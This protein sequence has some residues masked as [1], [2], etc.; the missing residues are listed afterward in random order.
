MK[1]TLAL[2]PLVMLILS[3]VSATN[4]YI[5]ASGNDANSG[6]STSTPWKTLN[7][8]NSFFS[9][10]KP[11]DNVYLNRGD[12]FYGSITINKSGASGSPITISAYGSGADPVI[13]GFTSVGSWTSVGTN[14]WE[15][16][17]AISSLSGC[18]MVLVNGVNVAMGR[19]PNSGY[20]TYQSFSGL[21]SLTSSSLGST[22]W[23]GAEVVIRKNDWTID[24][25]PIAA[26]AGTTITYINQY[27]SDALTAN[28]GFF[29][30]NDPR[31]LDAQNEWYYNPST[32]KIRVYS[33]GT[34][35]NVQVSTVSSLVINNGFDYINIDNIT[36]TGPSENAIYFSGG[37]SD[38]CNVQ[39]CTISYCGQNGILFTN[40]SNTNITNNVINVCNRAGV[41]SDAGSN[42]T[43]SGNTIT[44]IGLVVGQAYDAVK[45]DGIYAAST[46]VTIK[47]NVVK[48]VSYNGII[49][50]YATGNAMVQYNYVDGSN[51]VLDD[52]G[53]IYT[54]SKA[55]GTRT[56]DH[57]ISLNAIGNRDGTNNTTRSTCAGIYLDDNSNNVVVT[58]NTAANCSTDGF[59]LHKITGCTI[60]NN[61]SYNNGNRQVYFQNETTTASIYNNKMNNNIF[62][63]RSYNSSNKHQW[64]LGFTSVTNDIANFGTADYNYYARPISEGNTFDTY[65]SNTG[66]VNR[67]LAS[68]QSFTGQDAHSKTSPVAITD[69]NNL[70]FE[71]NASSSSKTINLG[72]TYIDMM[73]NSYNGSITLAPYSSAVLIKTGA[74]TN[75]P[76][77]A[78]AGSDQT[79]TLPASSVTL[80]GTGTDPDGSIASYK[81]SQVSG[82]STSVIVSPTA[83]S[84]VVNNLVQGVYKFQL[85][86][87]DNMGATG[88]DTVQVTVNASGSSLLLPALNVTN[89]NSGLQYNYYQ[90][91]YSTVP[92]FSTLTPTSSG[93]VS[94][95]T[96]SVAGRSTSFALQFNGYIKVPADGNYT[97]YTTSDDGSMLYIDDSLVVNNDGLHS[98]LEKSGSIGLKAGFHAITVGYTQGGGDST[99][100]VS[101]SSSSIS[102]Q[103]IPS[104]ILF[105]SSSLAPLSVNYVSGLDYYYYQAGFTTVP[106]FS[107]LTPTSSGTVNSFSLSVAKRNYGFALQFTGYIKI[108]ASGSYTFYTTSDDGSMLYIDGNAI[109]N[110]DGLHSAI[111]KSGTVSLT[112]GYHSIMVG[113]I[114]AG[115][116]STL[117]VS[118]SG[119]GISKQIIPSSILFRDA[120]ATVGLNNNISISS[121]P[122]T[123]IGI[124]VYPNPFVDNIEV[125]INSEVAGEYKLVLLDVLGRV[126]WMRSGSKT[127]G[128]LQQ[129]I[130][131]SAL[132]RGFYFLKVIQNNQQSVIKLERH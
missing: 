76:P 104:S 2:L 71:Y 43:I 75:Q 79:I 90:T 22:N 85:T 66:S 128:L 41:E 103:I 74:S 81:W 35:S 27:T 68:W 48:G 62:V 39:N 21:T 94:N 44:N 122:Q 121:M 95:F 83:A 30:Q 107:T 131:T 36:F 132:Q 1:K 33:A 84:T 63:A 45:T 116:D 82:P 91:G 110:N 38:Y 112:A 87:T 73:N 69:T 15:S 58:N 72:A 60:N 17:S 29:I 106:D 67:T 46:N 3:R 49:I 102:K 111:E 80:T 113:Y 37:S 18:N 89:A 53:G 5:A 25:C 96:V 61:T 97:F 120:N 51:L 108:A 105:Y 117:T 47:N 10:L 126:V 23:T 32:K 114:Q 92:D 109:V 11:G 7:K 8:L 56:I 99:L 65:Q 54:M 93:T 78:N 125:T 129:S 127:A 115:G 31:T 98:A 59:K 77:T 130:N 19:Y 14:V 123:Q 40:G 55:S 16:S 124:K 4:Y 34:P 24:R 20:L 9:S 118:Y 50:S 52:G 88:S 119:S 86:V 64:V 101:Y 28:Y 12:V 6:T 100:A 42:N 57:N 26:Q 13:T 70:R